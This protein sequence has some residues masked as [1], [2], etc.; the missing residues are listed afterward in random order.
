M[1]VMVLRLIM[2][3]IPLVIL[4]GC[5]SSIIGELEG[6]DSNTQHI[7]IPSIYRTN[8]ESTENKRCNNKIDLNSAS[9]DDLTNIIH[10]DE[11]KALELIENR[12]YIVVD[13]IALV[14]GIYGEKLNDIRRQGLACVER[15]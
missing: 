9:A 11:K 1:D 8:I 6:N 3:C 14:R 4:F 10:I 2:L 12:P 13:S 15:E 5:N 7:D